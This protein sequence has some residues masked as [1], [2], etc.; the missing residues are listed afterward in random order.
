MLFH[1][2]FQ[3]ENSNFENILPAPIRLFLLPVYIIFHQTHIVSSTC[4]FQYNGRDSL[5]A[6]STQFSHKNKK[7]VRNH[8]RRRKSSCICE[9]KKINYITVKGSL[10]FY[11][12]TISLLFSHHTCSH[13][14]M[15][16]CREDSS[17]EKDKSFTCIAYIISESL[18]M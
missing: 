1:R 7:I 11:S 14:W 9:G 13:V 17:A 2:A 5:G 18:V 6:L 8:K 15:Y 12:Q 4:I 10:F 3:F 16:V